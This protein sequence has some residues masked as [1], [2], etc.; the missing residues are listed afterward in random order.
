MRKT[1]PRS[2]ILIPKHAKKVFNGQLFD[3]YQWPQKMFDN[4]TKTFE[5]LR[6]ADTTH[7]IAIK[8]DRIILV[9]DEQPGRKA[10]IHFPG[11]RADNSDDSWLEAAKRELREETGMSFGHWRL[12]LVQQPIPKIEWFVVWFLATDFIGQV[13]QSID[14][15]GEKISVLNKSFETLCKDILEGVDPTMQYAVPVFSAYQTLKDLIAAPSFV[16]QEVDR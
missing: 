3:V 6:R 8:N 16:G 10:H 9:E 14:V 5:M 4:S 13:E 1:L 12:I 2:T 11:G 15:D 7:I